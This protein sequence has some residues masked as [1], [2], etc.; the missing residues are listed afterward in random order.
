MKAKFE[1]N[2]DYL[3]RNIPP[4]DIYLFAEETFMAALFFLKKWSEKTNL[5]E[6]M[7]R[8]P[9]TNKWITNILG[10]LQCKEQDLE[11]NLDLDLDS[12]EEV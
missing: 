10:L 3:R 9:I 11:I 1:K 5:T 8:D 6:E 2:V 4:D 12:V 7:L